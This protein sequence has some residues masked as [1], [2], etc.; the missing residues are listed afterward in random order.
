[1]KKKIWIA[2]SVVLALLAGGYGAINM[3][4]EKPKEVKKKVEVPTKYEIL[5]DSVK[6]QTDAQKWL[7]ET[8]K[9]EGFHTKKTDKETFVLISG[10]K[11]E[12]T[13]YG[14][15]LNAVKE[16]KDKIIVEYE[17]VAPSKTDKVEKKEHIPHMTLRFV[18]KDKPITG[19]VAKIK[20]GEKK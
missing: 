7:D 4:K 12:T 17:V 14:I 15:S 3:N 1:M 6:V 11:K 16:E 8:V 18:T 9:K 20:Q 19:T 2:I 13:G 10:G 5:D